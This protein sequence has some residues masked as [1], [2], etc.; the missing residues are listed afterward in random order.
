MSQPQDERFGTHK[1]PSLAIQS[2][3]LSVLCSLLLQASEAAVLRSELQLRER[4]ARS[5]QA[6][7]QV[8]RRA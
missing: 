7:Q 6:E 1:C 3:C 8:G 4:L 5:L 2:M